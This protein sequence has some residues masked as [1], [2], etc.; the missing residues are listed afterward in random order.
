MTMSNT[1]LKLVSAGVFVGC[2][3]IALRIA[4]ATPGVGISTLIIAGPTR[5]E[6]IDV[7]SE[8]DINEVEIKIKGSSDIWVVHNTVAPGGNTGWHS[9]LGPSIVSVKSGTATNYQSDDPTTPHVYT[10][11]SSFVDDGQHAHIVRNEG[12][13]NLELVA[14]QILPRGATRR[15]DQPAP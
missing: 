9:H 3:L 2:A 7:R 15:I 12:D 6:G 8:S 5:L 4:W 1:K 10:A 14:V 13:T 11:G